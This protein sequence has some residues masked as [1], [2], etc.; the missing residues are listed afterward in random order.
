[1]RQEAVHEIEHHGWIWIF[2]R[3]AEETLHACFVEKIGGRRLNG[4]LPTGGRVL[5]TDT[6]ST[7]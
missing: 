2:S 1:M 6:P 3:R 4:G 5:A 7:I